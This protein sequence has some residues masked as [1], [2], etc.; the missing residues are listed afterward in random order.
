M[1]QQLPTTR[2]FS[3]APALATTALL[4]C[5]LLT[6]CKSDAEKAEALFQSGQAYAQAGDLP[7][8]MVELRSVFQLDGAHR[9]ARRLYADLLRQEGDRKG[10]YAQL[11]RLVEQYPDDDS[12]RLDLVEM[13]LLSGAWQEAERQLARTRDLKAVR[14][15][16]FARALEYQQAVITANAAAKARI[17]E[18]ISALAALPEGDNRTARKIMIDAAL[19]SAEPLSALP[20]IEEAL[21][22]EPLQLDLHLA[23]V[24]LLA[25]GPDQAATE[26]A[27]GELAKLF[28]QNVEAREAM[29]RWYVSSGQIA[30]AEAF[31]RAQAGPDT[32]PQGP[33]LTHLEFLRTQV[34]AHEARAEAERLAGLNTGEAAAIYATLSASIRYEMGE[35]AE[36]IEALKALVAGAG[37]SDTARD[38]RVTLAR[39]LAQSGDLAA[40]EAL[41]E[42]VL[43]EDRAH[44]EALKTRAGW[45]IG[46]DDPARAIVDLRAAADQAPADPAIP[47][48]MAEAYLRDGERDLARDALAKSAE[49]SGNRA[50]EA[51]RYA[52]F[53]RAEGRVAAADQVLKSALAAAPDQAELHLALAQIYLASGREIEVEALAASVEGRGPAGA[54]AAQALRASV[55]FSK[56]DL[57]GGAALLAEKSVEQSPA[58]SQMIARAQLKAGQP[59]AARATMLSARAR[60][61][62][63][64][65]LALFAAS[66]ALAAQDQA[67]AEQVYREVIAADPSETRASEALHAL[68]EQ[69]GRTEE[70]DALLDG[71]LARDPRGFNLR[72]LK[73]AKLE[74]KGDIEGALAL[75][76]VLYAEA[77][78]NVVAANNLASM[79]ATYREDP[80]ALARASRVAKRLKGTKTPEFM[81]TY[82]WIALREGR[83]QEALDYLIPSA[84]ALPA[85][86]ATQ[87]HLAQ[88][89]D[90]AGQREAAIAQFR[91]VL[92]LE[93]E[94][95][96]RAS[97]EGRLAE[98]EA[99]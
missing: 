3:R 16:V 62:K 74:R 75:S 87:A 88:A 10:A 24:Q 94:A 49:I 4:A 5:L 55:L 57:A 60:A 67:G 30:R 45:R 40:A 68:L 44:I 84:N 41:V 48:L 11:L 59:D 8:A 99:Q 2:R 91:K 20:L 34:G 98:L 15:Q 36:A 96:L 81:D 46:A 29:V 42:T 76:E 35:K 70:A 72:L 53:L 1:T 82:G 86:A 63:D 77:P 92:A 32:G 66:V 14:A 28:P 97:V 83:V 47:A 21:Q 25:R 50:P 9:A 52:A 43:A 37:S 12:A 73:A 93:P 85:H 51:L 69:Q 89:Y 65:E 31:L 80:E 38:M 54:E 90:L 95:W 39:M 13:A 6:G 64:A 17:A 7:R 79:L 56:G 61:P 26:A 18:E 27:L 22:K 78:A 33:H 19:A 58:L 71:A 23:R